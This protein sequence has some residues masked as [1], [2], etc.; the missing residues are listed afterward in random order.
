MHAWICVPVYSNYTPLQSNYSYFNSAWKS[1]YHAQVNIMSKWGTSTCWEPAK[2]SISLINLVHLAPL[3]SLIWI[4]EMTCSFNS[5]CCLQFRKMFADRTPHC[6]TVWP[7]LVK[8]ELCDCT[9]LNLPGSVE[10]QEEVALELMVNICARWITFAILL[11]FRLFSDWLIT[12]SP[13]A[14]WSRWLWQRL[15]AAIHFS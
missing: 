6:L 9:W 12:L 14:V 15:F 11:K 13:K 10:I 7:T 5:A 1:Y 4:N 2:K 8:F 3:L